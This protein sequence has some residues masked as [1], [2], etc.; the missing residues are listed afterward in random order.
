M[1]VCMY[2]INAFIYL[3]VHLQRYEVMKNLPLTHVPSIHSLNTHYS[4]VFVYSIDIYVYIY[5]YIYVYLFII[6]GDMKEKIHISLTTTDK[7]DYTTLT[8]QAEASIP[9]SKDFTTI[10]DYGCKESF[11]PELSKSH[12]YVYIHT[13]IHTCIYMYIY[14]YIFIHIH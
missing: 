1:Y 10:M 2:V 6:L 11:R 13:Y 5:I 8:E 14:I 7:K 12:V 3:I 9:I 4:L